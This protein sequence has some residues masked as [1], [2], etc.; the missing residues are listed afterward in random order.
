M[1]CEDLRL[2]GA[3]IGLLGAL[4]LVGGCAPAQTTPG[5]AHSAPVASLA[6]EDGD[7]VRARAVAVLPKAQDLPR[8][9]RLWTRTDLSDTPGV[10]RGDVY[11]V[12][13]KD[14]RTL[15]AIALSTGSTLWQVTLPTPISGY[16]T[17]HMVGNDLVVVS[18]VPGPK[19]RSSSGA[20]VV[21]VSLDT[22][23]VRWARTVPCS[24]ARSPS[25][26][27]RLYLQCDDASHTLLELDPMTGSEAARI[28]LKGPAEFSSNGE[29]CGGTDTAIWCDGIVS[30]KLARSWTRNAPVADGTQIIEDRF[31]VS[32][33]ADMVAYDT[34]DG[35][36]VWKRPL[37]KSTRVLDAP[38]RLVLLND[39]VVEVLQVSDGAAIARA[40]S[41]SDGAQVHGDA[42]LTVLKPWHPEV[43]RIY[44]LGPQGESRVLADNVPDVH[45]VANRVLLTRSRVPGQDSIFHGYSL[46]HFAPPEVELPP[47]ERVTSVFERFRSPYAAG[48]ALAALQ[49]IPNYRDILERLL[50]S[51]PE[52]IK[53]S[54][55]AVA[56]LT[57][58]P[59]FLR[60]LK[61]DLDGLQN[62]PTSVDQWSEVLDLVGAMS[63]LDSPDA[64]K[65][66][67]A[68]WQRTAASLSPAW[69]RDVLQ[70]IVASAVWRY[71]TEHAGLCKH[72]AFPVNRTDAIGTVGTKSPSIAYASG[73]QRRWAAICEARIDDNANRRLEV[74]TGHHGEL[75]GDRMVPY[76]VLGTGPGRE[77]S[78]YV[79]GDPRGNYVVVTDGLCVQLVNT[80]TGQSVALDG[81]DG[82]AGDTVFGAHRAAAFSPNGKTLLY[83]RTHGSSSH[84][85]L[86]DLASGSERVLD[87]GPGELA[88]AFFDA[89]GRYVVVDLVAQ[90][91]DGDGVFTAPSGVTTLSPRL[92]RGTAASWSTFGAVGDKTKRR[93]ASVSTGI[94]RDR[95]PG[96]TFEPAQAPAPTEELVPSGSSSRR[97]WHHD[98]PLGPLHWEEREEE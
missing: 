34:K 14:L 65:A 29:I 93:V 53:T 80:R 13:A 89:S 69:R 81:A 59:R 70:N 75:L 96:E 57:R 90:D 40:S 4:V 55:R 47:E 50:E 60:V 17:V 77:I 21:Y 19:P 33:T 54:A 62:A 48:E 64:G 45:A 44:V 39:G 71:G 25:A 10:S 24:S 85:V 82:R 9:E 8:F 78:D 72:T 36:E 52:H 74:F 94:I 18:E 79:A 46:S 84:I 30:G 73:P 98:I 35:R 22:H 83:L 12:L 92:C 38:G 42:E 26:G 31:I 32:T 43:D 2:R 41:T 11:H 97:K 3:R 63:D 51:G 67:L 16:P 88:S 86:R 76:L 58:D 7:N 61:R 49:P 66:L 91:T 27:A 56:G 28:S 15:H 95:R 37:S 68:Y 5:E 87:P 20:T 6:P 23:S 1:T